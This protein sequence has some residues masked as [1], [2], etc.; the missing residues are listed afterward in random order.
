M[1]KNIKWKYRK[2][3]GRLKLKREQG[4]DLNICID[5]TIVLIQEKVYCKHRWRGRGWDE[6]E[7]SRETYTLPY[8]K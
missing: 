4:V 7:N 5:F 2:G 6:F 3:E 1:R 8:A